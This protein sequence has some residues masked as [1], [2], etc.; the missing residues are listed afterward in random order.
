[1]RERFGN[2]NHKII[3]NADSQITVSSASNG[4]RLS[5]NSTD[6]V[7]A[8]PGQPIVS[9][10]NGNENRMS[11]SS[12]PQA[13]KMETETSESSILGS[14]S[15]EFLQAHA[16]LDDLEGLDPTSLLDS[17]ESSI[18]EF[19]LETRLHAFQFML[20]NAGRKAQGG[21]G[22][23]STT[24]NHSTLDEELAYAQPRP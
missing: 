13:A 15:C 9:M 8:E 10:D 18:S 7:L 5:Q 3:I 12:E 6:S 14:E 24:D 11:P 19:A 17:Q 22:L 4:T 16:N 2:Y 1:M 21:I 23:L 20:Q